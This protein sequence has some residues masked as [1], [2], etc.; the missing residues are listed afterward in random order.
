MKPNDTYKILIVDDDPIFTA[1]AT[2]CLSGK[3]R[4][5]VSA[6]D[7]AEALMHLETAIFQLALVDLTMPRIDGF[8]LIAMLRATPRLRALK[9]IVVSSRDD[10]SA[11]EEA[12]RLGIDGYLTKPVNWID[13]RTQV[14]QFAEGAIPQ[15]IDREASGSSS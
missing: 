13:L 4:T 3:G 8:R 7:G 6:D 2:T 15:T 12:T 9:I 11:I 5:I 10:S 1:T 14:R